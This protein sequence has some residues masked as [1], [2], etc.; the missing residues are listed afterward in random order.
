VNA[1]TLQ[2]GD[3]ATGNL[4]G[5]SGVAVA[6]NATLATN[7]A[8][9]A[10]FAA[11]VNL[12]GANAAFNAVQSGTN[13]ITSVISGTGGFNQ[14][15]AGTTI[16]SNANL[17][18]GNTTV[19]AGTLEVGG[20]IASLNTIVNS[21]GTLR[22]LGTIGGNV[23]NGGSVRPG[24]GATVGA[25]NVGGNYTQT[26]GGNLSIRLASTSSFDRL[27]V[28][29][30]ASV[31]G[32]LT[33]VAVNGFHPAAGQTYTFLTANGGV[34]GTF[35]TVND[36][37]GTLLKLGVTYGPTSA[38]LVLTQ[39]PIPTAPG[40]PTSAPGQSSSSSSLVEIP[41]L[42]P[43]QGAVA[44][45]INGAL[46]DPRMGKLLAYLNTL[47]LGAIPEALTRLS[48]AD[49]SAYTSVT[50]SLANIQTTNLQL[51]TSSL[52]AGANGFS[53][54]GFH[55]AGSGPNYAGT[56]G[57]A[58]PT[59]LGEKD[60]VK[61]VPPP[62]DRVAAFLTGV[63]EWV[64]V[65]TT[66]NA[67]GYDLAAGGFSVGMD[68]KFTPHVI[69]G[70]S[71][72]YDRTGVDLSNGGNLTVDGG[73]LGVYGTYF[74]GRF[75][76]DV[77][78]TGGLNGY[79]SRRAALLGNARGSTDGGELDTLLGLGYDFKKGALTFGPVANFQYSH[80][81]IDGFTE[82]GSLAPLKIGSQTE[83]SL[84]T[85]VGIKASYDCK[86][87]GV[88]IRPELRATWQHEFGDTV[89]GV[90]SSFANGAGNTFTV[91]GPEI[92]R[93]SAL[94]GAGFTI[95]WNDR[96]SSYVYYDG[97]LGRKNYESTSVT[98]GLRI[99]F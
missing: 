62:N 47:P 84:R 59:G 14:N 72:G 29:G 76:F 88:I 26:S 44:A 75:Y 89:H 15:G 50:S 41:S 67:R 7:L 81:S 98:G 54:Q 85:A 43:N 39:G 74:T 42:S 58:G 63:G 22:G 99:A 87:G 45:A 68:Y 53:A 40:Q 18:T 20:S 55:I 8:D 3:G 61:V 35:S 71:A 37:T 65:G 36:Q 96:T 83:D 69:V 80:V 92:G 97:E 5:T 90:P 28:G 73:K 13:T 21:G 82:R 48:P 10:T 94:L 32:S 12:N 86:V 52:R 66:E 17:Y 51:R 25:L 30:V 16:L 57:A 2:V 24:S 4:T 91:F 31:N 64:N 34:N 49:L 38:T 33:A 78:V 6:N 1:G 9:G 60:S 77:G 23:S 56:W 93:D 11:N 46:S 19:N 95:F 79:S 27:L 70:L